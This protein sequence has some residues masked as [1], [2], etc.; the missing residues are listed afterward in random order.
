MTPDPDRS[1]CRCCGDDGPR[2]VRNVPRLRCHPTAQLWLMEHQDGALGL[3]CSVCHRE[4]LRLPRP[5]RDRLLTDPPSPALSEARL[6]ERA[7]AAARERRT[8]RRQ[9]D[10]YHAIV[11]AQHDELT[12]LRRALEG[13][14]A[15][16]RELVALLRHDRSH[17]EEDS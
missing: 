15:R 14:H 11:H 9:L 8:Y 4:R 5:S 2:Y 16:H 7:S 17:P 10:R 3:Q 6:L 1:A 12:A 13:L